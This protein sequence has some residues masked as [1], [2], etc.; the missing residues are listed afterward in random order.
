MNQFNDVKG[1]L[2]L[3]NTNK[4]TQGLRFKT[5]F[6]HLKLTDISKQLHQGE[7]PHKLWPKPDSHANNIGILLQRQFLTKIIVLKQSCREDGRIQIQGAL[8]ITKRK[9]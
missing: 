3:H 2:I 8:T 4:K 1:M 9:R 7:A 5:K 6:S